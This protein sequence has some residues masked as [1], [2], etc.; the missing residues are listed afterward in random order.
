MG[1]PAYKEI[2][3][4]AEPFETPFDRPGAPE[5]PGQFIFLGNREDGR[6]SG[7]LPMDF[8]FQGL[9]WGLAEYFPM[10]YT[11]LYVLEKC[12]AVHP[13][14][15]GEAFRRDARRDPQPY[16]PKKEITHYVFRE[17]FDKRGY[18]D[19]IGMTSGEER[20]VGMAI[21]YAQTYGR[22]AV[23]ARLIRQMTWH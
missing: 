23:V 7:M 18:R 19:V 9:G 4:Q 3:G 1:N 22:R 20:A 11:N 15:T 21:R 8:D 14:P 16:R 12:C 17:P 6:F 13:A 5:V 10:G 2:P